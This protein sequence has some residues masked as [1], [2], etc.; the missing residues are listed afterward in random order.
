[1]SDSAPLLKEIFVKALEYTSQAERNRYLAEACAGNGELHAEV[2]S[3][4]KADTDAGSFLAH[5][6]AAVG[7]AAQQAR[8][9][10][11]A[12]DTAAES[13]AKKE[14]LSLDFLAPAQK[15]GSLGRLGHYEILEVIGRGGMGVVL[16]AFDGKLQRVV[17]IKTMLPQLA[18]SASARQRFTREAQAAAAIR[19]EHVI[20]IYAVEDESGLPYLVMEYISGISLQER[21]DRGRLQIKEILRIGMQTARGLAAAHA[22]GLVH[23]DVKPANVLLEN[24]VERVKITDFGLARTVDDASLTQS[25]VIAGTPHYMSP[26]QARGEHMDHRADLFSLGSLLYVMCTGRP[27]FRAENTMAVLKRVCE[28]TPHAVRELNAEVPDWLAALITRLHA[29]DPAERFASA[30]EVA[31]YLENGLAHLHQPATVPSPAVLAGRT[32]GPATSRRRRWL[33]VAGAALLVAG[34]V[35]ASPH[36]FEWRRGKDPEPVAREKD[37]NLGAT[38][39]TE[40]RRFVGHTQEARDVALAADGLRALSC[41]ADGTIRLWDVASGQQLRRF[42]GHSGGVT[43]ATFSP[44][45]RHALSCG[46]DRTI[47]LWELDSGRQVGILE[48]HEDEVATVAFSPDGKQVLSGCGKLDADGHL[49]LWDLATGKELRRFQGHKDFVWSVAFSKDGLHALSGSW[50]HTARL[51]E[52]A[53]GKEIKCFEGHTDCILVAR[54]AGD[55][56]HVVTAGRD[57]TIRLWE[58]DSGKE[59][60]SFL[61]HEHHVESL[62]VSADGR[63]ILSAGYD[64]TLRLW[65]VASRRELHR[66]DAGVVFS[67]AFS[68]DGTRAVTA[69]QDRTVRLWRLPVSEPSLQVRLRAKLEGH[70]SAGCVAF[71]PEGKILASAGILGDHTIKLWDLTPLTLPSPPGGEGGVRGKELAT[72]PGHTAQITWLAFTPDGTTLASASLDRTVRLWDVAARKEREPALLHPNMVWALGFSPD[73]KTLATA[74]SDF[75]AKLWDTKTWTEEATLPTGNGARALA[76]A[77]KAKILAVTMGSVND[78]KVQLWNLETRQIHATLPGH[79]IGPECVAFDPDGAL[80]ATG[81]HDRTVILWD[82]AAGKKLKTLYHENLV[83][84]VSFSADG[85]IL[86]SCDGLYNRPEEPGAA[87]LWDVATRKELLPLLPHPGCVFAVAF[88]PRD[89][90]LATACADGIIRLWDVIR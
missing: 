63:R 71:H 75:I 87:K 66:F 21:L 58:I 53:T 33:A 83:Q 2:E 30:A 89:N 69:G 85:K 86:A 73:A 45:G 40:V 60:G 70:A 47:R 84:G 7:A 12:T 51:W 14:E 8:D 28:D 37:R 62:A 42:Q 15:A 64:G 23:R 26:E 17:A 34:A 49:R 25:G 61:G 72:L 55:G 67:V 13:G 80:L 74:G 65:D 32:A 10:D 31:Q 29:K 20:G 38:T 35:L 36:I 44:D 16:K 68:T 81:G 90:I 56:R 1:M 3:L 48:G 18:T 88:S 27:P 57:K 54:F 50:D 43:K 9:G 77:P 24:G 5:P 39:I 76:F 11:P 52:V 6:A 79:S 22:Q 78:P 4:L 19:N 46:Q 59:V 82:V 41:S